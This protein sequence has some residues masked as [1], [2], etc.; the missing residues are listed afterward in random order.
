MKEQV[1][2]VQRMQDYIEEHLEEEITMSDLAK[3]SLFSLRHSYWLFRQYTGMTSAAYIRSLRLSKSAMRL[4]SGNY[5]VTDAA[6]DFG[7][8]SIDGYTRAFSR[9]FGRNP[10]EYTRSPVLI[11]LFV[12]YGAKFRE[13]RKDSVNMENLQNLFQI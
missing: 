9:E 1:I 2:V 11:L 7:F 8:D 5:R 12:P 4:K 6:L 3:A 10:G 13:L